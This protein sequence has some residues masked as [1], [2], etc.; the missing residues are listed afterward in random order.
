MCSRGGSHVIDEMG[1]HV[2][3]LVQNKDFFLTQDS[4]NKY[5]AVLLYLFSFFRC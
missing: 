5:D 1:S 4:G 3:E 2:A